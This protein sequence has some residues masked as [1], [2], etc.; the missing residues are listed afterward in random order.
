MKPAGPSWGVRAQGELG[1]DN[2]LLVGLSKQVALHREMDVVANNLANLNTTGFKRES[3]QFEEYL[4]SPARADNFQLADRKIAFVQDRR[5]LTDYSEGPLQE[6]GSALDIAI[7]GDGYLV[8]NTPQGERY[9]RNGSLSLD[10]TG[11]LVTSEGYPVQGANGP[12]QFDLNDTNILIAQ[13]GS[14]STK[15]GTQTQNT[16]R[17]K[18]KLVRFDQP[19][20]LQK[21][22]LSL[23]SAGGAQPQP[24]TDTTSIVQGSLEKSN[25]KPIFEMSRMIE[26]MRSY[27]AL[28]N[29]MTSTD[30][31]RKTAIEKLAQVSA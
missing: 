23:Y 20:L 25:V 7:K 12:I 9:T 4:S 19:G 3:V 8:V 15:N 16:E 28:A 21:Q 24:V 22:G 27:S 17:G 30:D 10:K 26:V 13:D 1:M 31:L 6:T 29:M 2:A 14:I 5:T 11:Q 18:I